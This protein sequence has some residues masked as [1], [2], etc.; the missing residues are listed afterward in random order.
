[1]VKKGLKQCQLNKEPG[2]ETQAKRLNFGH[3]IYSLFAGWR[4][5]SHTATAAASKNY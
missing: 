3:V 1:M 4:H 5:H 2:Q